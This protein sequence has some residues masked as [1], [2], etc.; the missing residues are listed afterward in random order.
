MSTMFFK[1][2]YKARASPSTPGLNVR[3]LQYI[4]T[5]PG[6]V[7][8]RGCGFGLW[9]RLPGEREAAVQ[10]N[11][12]LAKKV[13]REASAEHTLYRAIFSVGKEDAETYGLYHR[14]R[15]E[16]LVGNHIG[17]IAREMNIRPENLCYCA[18]FHCAKG[19]PHVHILY[20]DCG[21]DPQPE[22]I[23]K[24][25]WEAK[26]ERIRA[27]FAGDIHREEIQAAQKEQ[28]EQIRPL[29]MAIQALC[30]EANPEKVLDMPR[31]YQSG[32]LNG[33]SRQLAELVK[34]IPAKGSLRYAYLP[35]AYRAKVD[36]LVDR[37]LE[38][39]ELRREAETYKRCSQ[40]ISRLYGNGEAGSQ[41]NFQKAW[42]RL[43][44]ALC[45][46]VMDAVREV[47]REVRASA[48]SER[49]GLREFLQAAAE[50]APSLESYQALKGMLPRE[51]IPWGNMERKI[52]GYHD[53]MNRV[54]GDVLQDARVRLRLQGYALKEAGI[55]LDTKKDAWHRRGVDSKGKLEEA[56][57]APDPAQP[58]PSPEK[59]RLFGKEV[60][61]KEWDA[62]QE[63]YR[64]AKH[65][66]RD[67]LT[68]Q[69]RQEA[70]WTKEAVQT[71]TAMLLMGIMRLLSQAAHQ[72]QAERG[73]HQERR[74][75]DKSR[76]QRK[77]ER[78]IQQ[79]ESG[80]GT[81]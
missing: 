77:N 19:H 52:P 16:R 55:D 2:S 37:C 65:A 4:A 51:R 41:K 46:E 30:R 23:P 28:R 1:Q 53:Q 12:E 73:Y 32:S 33:L 75:R 5:R 63:A 60:E 6:T 70:G 74:S 79:F 14:E 66:L 10:T 78:A 13:V 7:Y 58:A 57:K 22:G 47:Q 21:K 76:E 61:M 81:N 20:W 54:V 48:P 71:S 15:W 59:H 3:H 69:L 17:D 29:R 27:A 72:R 45:N 80:W 43:H 31:L 68:T 40:E 64:D 35:A 44:R 49:D 42:E 25:M 36:A 24:S 11:L 62:Y 26:A 38:M 18:S 39:P 56:P 34:E 50:A 67:A 8:N 9:G